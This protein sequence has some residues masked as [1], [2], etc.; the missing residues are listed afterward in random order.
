[1]STEKVIEAIKRDYVQTYSYRICQFIFNTFP[2]EARKHFGSVENCVKEVA[3]DA[4]VWFEKWAPNYIA[5][6]VARVKGTR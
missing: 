6:I 5:G 3:D 4:E 1:M 2:E